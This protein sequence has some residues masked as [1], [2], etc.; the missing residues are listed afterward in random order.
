MAKFSF[1]GTWNDSW[2]ILDAL[3]ATGE[4]SLLPDLD[5]DNPEPIF[6]TRLD[7]AL[8]DIMLVHRDG[9]LWSP[10]FSLYPPGMWRVEEGEKAGKYNVDSWRGGPCLRL[11]LPACYIENGAIQLAP[12]ALYSPKWTI[13][14]GSDVPESPSAAVRKGFQAVKALIKRQLVRLKA[15]PDIWSGREASRL[16][17]QGQATIHGFE[18]PSRPA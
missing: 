12:G 9:Y 6:A 13:K 7:D 5:Y 4:Y 2:D 3:F 18:R 17:E 11:F 14:P 15:R 8:K 10:K 1:L 16:V